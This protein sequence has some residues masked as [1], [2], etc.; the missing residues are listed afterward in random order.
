[1]AMGRI[2]S[3]FAA[4]AAAI[5]LA[6]LPGCGG[7]GEKPQGGASSPSP[8]PGAAAPLLVH[9]GGT[10]RTAMQEIARIYEKDTGQKVEINYNDSG[11]LL[12]TI[13][14]TRKGDIY[15]CHDPFLPAAEKKGFVDKSCVPATLRPVIVVKKGNPK[16]VKGV[17]DLARE[18]VRVGLTDA[19]FSTAGNIA[20]IFFKRAGIAEAMEKKEIARTRSGGQMADSVKV[21]TN[22]AAIV[23]NAVAWARRDA[24]DVV[25][26]EEKFRPD[27]EADAVTT[28][29]YGKLDMSKVRV[30]AMTLTC[31]KQ[32]ENARKLL[33]M[34]NSKRGR[35]VFAANGFL[36][37]E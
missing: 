33:D 20:P 8:A 26:I 9:V 16:G 17:K 10:M 25:E 2:G 31:S 3:F 35:E 12:I 30:T 6:L 15:V 7:E 28:A 11:S 32:L 5:T 14:Q 27:A 21:G 19:K 13:E 22:D 1:M 34:V 29:T 24:L 37:G 4:A 23:W 36:P 18:D